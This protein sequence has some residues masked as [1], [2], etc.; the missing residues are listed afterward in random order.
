M[1]AQAAL[2]NLDA[3]TDEVRADLDADLNFSDDR[4]AH[5]VIIEAAQN[6]RRELASLIHDLEQELLP[7]AN[8]RRFVVEGYDGEVEVKRNIKRTAWRHDELLPVVIAL[9]MDEPATI[10][11]PETGELL[12]YTQ[13]GLNVAR[14]LRE[15]V[16]F[17]AGKVG[18][19]RP[20]GLDPDEFCTVTED[21][22]SV[23]IPKRGDRSDV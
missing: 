4:N 3:L 9:I 2:Q 16:G 23:K 7:L 10:F 6:A 15:C 17:G 21:G 19:L 8:E 12:P 11:D 5:V 14:R 20:I 13:I 1:S 22:Y 18:G